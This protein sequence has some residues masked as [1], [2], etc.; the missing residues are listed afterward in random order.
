MNDTTEAV[1][2]NSQ[3][4]CRKHL[5]E[6]SHQPRPQPQLSSHC[7]AQ[8]MGLQELDPGRKVDGFNYTE[9]YTASCRWANRAAVGS[10]EVWGTNLLYPWL[11][12][13]HLPR[14]SPKILVREK[15]IFLGRNL[16][17]VHFFSLQVQI[18]TQIRNRLDLKLN[19]VLCFDTR[20]MPFLNSGSMAWP[21]G[22]F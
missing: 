13:S 6:T 16:S 8:A 5:L 7:Q 20:P 21:H 1:K 15:S 11:K 17:R 10:C 12:T 3:R 2:T 9:T 4:S 22:S 18:S 19:P 14:Q